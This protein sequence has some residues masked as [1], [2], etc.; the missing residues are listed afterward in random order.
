MMPAA[1]TLEC[2]LHKGRAASFPR[3]SRR[4][5]SLSAKMPTGCA[6]IIP[7]LTSLELAGTQVAD[8]SALKGKKLTRLSCSKTQ[9]SDLTPLAGMPL[10][11]LNIHECSKLHDLTPLK[12]M[13]LTEIVLTPANFTKD[14][15]EVLRE[16]KSLKIVV[17]GSKASDRL[18][19]QDFWKK[20]DEGAFKP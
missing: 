10:T 7:P 12:G 17:T 1:S 13:N 8:L 16:C 18:T 19:A 5:H 3:A 4:S 15:L 9:V 11:S 20:V 2:P 14:K 6:L